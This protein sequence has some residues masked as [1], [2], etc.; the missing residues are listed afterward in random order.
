MGM[1]GLYPQCTS[2]SQQRVIKHTQR[3]TY[4]LLIGPYARGRPVPNL[5]RCSSSSVVEKQES[6]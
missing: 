6:M 1:T 5:W 3:F 2:I 4:S